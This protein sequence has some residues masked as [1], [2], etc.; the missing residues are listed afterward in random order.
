[1]F[2]AS[3]PDCCFHSFPNSKKLYFIFLCAVKLHNNRVISE[4]RKFDLL[5][6]LKKE[7]MS[8][9]NFGFRLSLLFQFFTI[10]S[11]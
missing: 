1:M 4:K 8:K 10:I 5:S 6:I 2:I 7:N 3:A 11:K 9:I